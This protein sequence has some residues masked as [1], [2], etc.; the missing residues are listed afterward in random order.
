MSIENYKDMLSVIT[1]KIHNSEFNYKNS[2]IVGDNSSGKSEILK[3]LVRLSLDEYYFIDA[4]NRNFDSSKIP[5]KMDTK[6]SKY[7][8]IT[9][10]R[11]ED[12]IFNLSDSFNVFGDSTG[13][14]EVIFMEYMDELK[15]LLKKFLD[16]E[17]SIEEI[18]YGGFSME[19]KLSI[20]NNLEKISNGYQAIIRL[21]LELIYVNQYKNNITIVIDEIDEYLSPKNKSKIISFIQKEFPDFKW[22]FTTHSADVIASIENF[23]LII[24]K[25]NNYECLDSNDFSTITDVQEIF[26]NLYYTGFTDNSNTSTTLRRLLS[27]KISDKWS[28]KEDEDLVKIDESKLTN[29]QRLILRQIKNW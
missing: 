8:D 24:L 4:V 29:S 25:G 20:N 3:L 26:R 6:S 10:L 21:F 1:N 5:D 12:N 28:E 14:I 19:K 18:N 7:Q 17:I 9:K 11:L 13:Y 22:I 27:F 23:N 16:I 15:V 2:V